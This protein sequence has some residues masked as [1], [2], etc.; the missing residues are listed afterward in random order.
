ML[1]NYL[2]SIIRSLF[3]N[4]IYTFFSII[5][6]TLGFLCSI[7][8]Y[9]YISHELS[10][11]EFFENADRIARLESTVSFG[12]GEF[13]DYAILASN[14]SLPV[15]SNS[16]PHIK[17]RTRLAAL[18]QLFV[19]PRG[20]QRFSEKYGM[21]AD[22]NFFDIF[23]FKVVAGNAVD[24]L[25]APNSIVLTRET[26]Q[27]YFGNANPVG[28]SITIYDRSYELPLKV[29]AVME[30]MPSNSHFKFN[31]LIS[32][33]AFEDLYGIRFSE[34]YVLY[35]YLLLSPGANKKN[36]ET[37][38]TRLWNKAHQKYQGQTKFRLRPLTGIHLHSSARYEIEPNSSIRYVYILAIIAGIILVVS[39]INFI[40]LFLS[41]SEYRYKGLGIR[42]ILG[43]GS[44]QLLTQLFLE[45]V[46][47]SFVSFLIALLL[48]G[49]VLPLFNAL[50]D[51]NFVFQD[52]LSNGIIWKGFIFS[53]LIGIISAVYP[54]IVIFTRNRVNVS[55]AHS[56]NGEQKGWFQNAIIVTQFAASAILIIG[57]LVVYSQL[58]FIQEKNLGFNEQGI[59]TVPNLLGEKADL[60]KELLSDN[61][62]IESIS[63]SA[64]IPGV[65]K[66]GGTA[67][68]KSLSNGKEI[69]ANWISTD[70]NYLE[71]YGIPVIKGRSFSKK[72]A[73]DSLGAYMINEAAVKA[74]GLEHPVGK[75]IT[76]ID[77]GTV[78]GVV[79][80][81]NYLSLRKQIPPMVF[82]LNDNM[83]FH[84]S[85]KL[86]NN[87]NIP[88]AL[89]QIEN[90]WYQ[91]RPDAPFRYS[92][93]QDKISKLYK[94]ERNLGQMILAFAIIAIFVACLG[95]F[96]L[97]AFSMR[98]RTKEIGIRKVLGATADNILQLFYS[99]Y[100][101][102]ILI[103]NAIAFPLAYFLSRY[104]LANFAYKIE[105]SFL[106]FLLSLAITMFF[107]LT[108]LSYWALKAAW[109]NPVDS[110]RTE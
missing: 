103:A 9:L 75:Q 110:I 83:Y 78:I 98:K 44:N 101:K 36:I 81:F 93:L 48:L 91:V 18:P 41:E 20:Q 102:L 47:I 32:E 84:L 100:F 2:K 68:V 34:T 43:A 24:P 13:I 21:A 38:L 67:L 105:I 49:P 76:A 73:T 5:S 31:Y 33:S 7:F 10:Y 56:V 60:F 62:D 89:A 8:A 3:R 97:A 27:K 104:W 59:I 71:I 96:S 42:K 99:K 30:N 54:A 87:A 107:T 25:A 51:K 82:W 88:A 106:P 80:N 16:F 11:D 79:K 64:Y 35:Q 37:K 94:S 26:A 19:Q 45:S 92:F 90:A 57:T 55:S 39:C 50:V 63:F 4:R 29:S 66:S 61:K 22:S 108:A 12:T 14:I 53:G 69:T 40:S 77:T 86:A 65:S 74:L 85:I 109:L 6:L 70:Y 15:Q 17:Q 58:N 46:I 52:F 95:L 23:S 72:Y 1:Y 28:K